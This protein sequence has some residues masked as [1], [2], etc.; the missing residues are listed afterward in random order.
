M[1]QVY[2]R[3]SSTEI[4]RIES[5]SR[6]P[7]F[8]NFSQTLAGISTIRAHQDEERFIKQLEMNTDGN[9]VAQIVLQLAFQW[10]SLRL[11]FIGSFTSFFIVALALLAPDFIPAGSVAIGLSFSF[12]MCGYLKVG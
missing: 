1:A 5:I 4:Q 6:S 12:D 2:F 7:I 9:S 11:D 8:A 10:L 3:K